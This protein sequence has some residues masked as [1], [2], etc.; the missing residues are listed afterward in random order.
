MQKFGLQRNS[1]KLDS[2][3]E[4]EIV[5]E[6]ATAL[7]R[8]GKKLRLALQDFAKQS[9]YGMT[10]EQEATMLQQ[11]SNCVWE[12]AIQREFVGFVDGN[13]SWI[14]DNYQIPDAAIT[15]LGKSSTS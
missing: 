4:R 14:R 2:L 15:M 6:Q 12:L 8:A 5:K 9:K 3:L 13:L 10:L 1:A 7:G 11:I